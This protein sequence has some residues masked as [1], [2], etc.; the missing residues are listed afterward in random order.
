[1]KQTFFATLTE[2]WWA[3]I[4]RGALVAAIL[5]FA[6][7]LPGLKFTTPVYQWADANDLT[8]KVLAVNNP[9]LIAGIGLVFWF[10]LPFPLHYPVVVQ[11]ASFGALL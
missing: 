7:A 5:L 4:I 3:V 6:N 2:D 9:L 1:M 10:S 8:T 11:A